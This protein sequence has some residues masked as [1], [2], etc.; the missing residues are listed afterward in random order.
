MTYTRRLDPLS[1]ERSFV[2]QFCEPRKQQ[3]L[4]LR[5]R[6][7]HVVSGEATRFTSLAELEAF[8]Q[9]VLVTQEDK[10]PGSG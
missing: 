10:R 9:N 8:M 1:P 3:V 7:E 6:V 5:G 2:V 4:E